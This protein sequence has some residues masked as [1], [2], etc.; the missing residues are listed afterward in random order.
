MTQ[1]RRDFLIL[2]VAVLSFLTTTI[3]FMTEP[4]YETFAIVLGAIATILTLYAGK[5]KV[6][7]AELRFVTKPRQLFRITVG[8]WG[9]TGSGKTWLIY[10]LGRILQTRY[11]REIDGLTYGLETVNK[12]DF[13]CQPNEPTQGTDAFVFKFERCR[14]SDNYSQSIS[15]FRHEIQIFDN[16]GGWTTGP[17]KTNS[18]FPYRLLE[19]NP[20]ILS[21][22]HADIVVIVLDPTYSKSDMDEYKNFQKTQYPKL[23]RELIRYLESDKNIRKRYYAVCITKADTI[24]GG[25]YLNPDALIEMHFGEEM[26]QA[27]S[28]PDK[29][30]IKTFSTS[31]AGFIIGNG[32]NHPNLDEFQCN[33]RDVQNWQPYGVEFPFFWAFEELEKQSLRDGFQKTWWKRLNCERYLKKHIPYPNLSLE[34]KV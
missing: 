10:A 2:I 25:V 15:S 4:S 16:P 19:S 12:F 34:F 7:K 22:A 28:I 20:A 26:T 5:K 31:S 13:S 17:F 29:E 8:L 9:T 1:K 11:N 14:N 6:E 21:I 18:E 3:R 24:D 27:L 30:R 32:R 33:L 23:V